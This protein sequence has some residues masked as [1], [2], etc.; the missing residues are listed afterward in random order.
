MPV[1]RSG[2]GTVVGGPADGDAA[3]AFLAGFSGD[4]AADGGPATGDSGGAFVAGFSGDGDATAGGAVAV[5]TGRN[6]NTIYLRPWQT[7]SQMLAYTAELVLGDLGVDYF[8]SISLFP[9]LNDSI[10]IDSGAA[11][12]IVT[13]T[14]DSVRDIERGRATWAALYTDSGEQTVPN[15]KTGIRIKHAEGDGNVPITLSADLKRPVR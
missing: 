1:P 13:A 5:A 10:T 2:D 4:G 3:G 9:N 15:A 12:I 11:T 7:V 8:V 6:N 14:T